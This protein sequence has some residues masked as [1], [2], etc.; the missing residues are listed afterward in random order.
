[1]KQY[2]LPNVFIFVISAIFIQ[3]PFSEGG[4]IYFKI[5]IIVHTRPLSGERK[6]KFL[7]VK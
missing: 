7:V 1:M 3:L 5:V 2:I 4:E 6:V